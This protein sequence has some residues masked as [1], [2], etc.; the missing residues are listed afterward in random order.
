[1]DYTKLRI[2]ACIYIALPILIFS[3]GFLRWYYAMMSVLALGFA[4]YSAIAANNKSVD[5]EK[6]IK[7]KIS[8]ISYIFLFSLIWTYLGGM[9]GC[10]YQSSDWN[11]RN[12]VYFDLISFDWPIIYDKTGAALVYYIGHWLPPA[13]F[14]KFILVLTQSIDLAWFLGKMVFW[15]WTS[16]GLTLVVLLIIRFLNLNDLKKR[17]WTIVIFSCFSGLDIV[18]AVLV[19]TLGQML[20][21]E[22]IHLEWWNHKYQFSSITTCIFWV[23]N[24]VIIP[25]I[26]TLCFLM[27]DDP[28]NYMFYCVACMI[29]GPYPCVGLVICMITKVLWYC[30]Q[31]KDPLAIK[32]KLKR[33]FSLSNILSFLFVFPF[34]AMYLLSND[35]MSQHGTNNSNLHVIDVMTVAKVFAFLM[36]EVGCYLILIAGSHRKNPIYYC[37][38]ITF[39]IAPFLQVGSRRDFCMRATV[40]AIFILMLYVNGYVLDNFS[41]KKLKKCWKT[42]KKSVCAAVLAVLLIFG[43][44]TPVIEV[45]RGLY[46]INKCGTIFLEDLSIGS[47]NRT[48]VDVTNFACTEPENSLFFKNVARGDIR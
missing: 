48:D 10:F 3:V 29:C 44:A 14:G 42:S 20:S 11:C 38:I 22:Y 36:L 6:T 24:Q 32:E 15:I 19:N 1:M 9:N 17:F 25:W 40:P 41:L 2:A 33:I 34:V 47:F 16:I 43:A 26:I 7:M 5:F 21:E 46:F 37:M 27:E 8:E 4:F 39:I 28:R 23:F 31:Y 30:I 45:Y 13:L 35:A 18:G 12:A